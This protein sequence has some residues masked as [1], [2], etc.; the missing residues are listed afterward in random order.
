MI[1]LADLFNSATLTAMV[2]AGYVRIHR[3]PAEPLVI[4]NYTEKAQYESVWNAVTLTCRGLIADLDGTVVARPFGKFF[5]YGQPGAPEVALDGPVRVTDKA[6]GSL[7]VIYPDSSGRYAVATRGSFTSEQAVHA[8]AVLRER[9]GHWTPPAGRTV[10]VE[11]IYPGNR[12]VLDYGEL[13]DLVLLGAVDLATGR[14]Y[15]PDGVPDWPGPVVESFDY[16]TLAQAL[17][18]PARDRR[19][20]LVIWFPDTDVRVKVKYEEYVRL[21]RIVTGLSARTV[22]ERLADLDALVESLPDEFHGWVRTVAAELLAEVDERL[23]AIED[24]YLSIVDGLADGW[25][26]KDFALVAARHPLR[27]ALFLRLDGK[28]CRP[29]LW[30]QVRQAADR[31]FGDDTE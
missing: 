7:G 12:I 23:A 31:T 28:D 27:G 2:Q 30:Q 22:W 24:A 3:H 10:L 25:S 20:G 4:H 5:N 13:D 15:G 6:D 19:E 21:H 26:R 29:L 18:A 8:T 17:A 9:Y 11:I 1:T 14:T 16:P